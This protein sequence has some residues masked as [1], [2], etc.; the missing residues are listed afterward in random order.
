M[1][2]LKAGDFV[3]TIGDAH[4]YMNHIEPLKMQLERTPRNAPTIHIVKEA[5]TLEEFT[6]GHFELRGYDPHP[7]VKMQMAV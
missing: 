6:F 4:V 3:H 2:N 1:T 5:T 7:P